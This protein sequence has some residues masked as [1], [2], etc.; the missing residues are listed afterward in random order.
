MR[1]KYLGPQHFQGEY[2]SFAYSLIDEGIY[3]KACV[4][5]AP[6]NVRGARLERLVKSPLQKYA[7]LTGKDGYLTSHI[8][9]K[10]H[11][12]SITAA[13]HFEKNIYN[14]CATQLNAKAAEERE[15]NRAAL[16]E[17]IRA[18][19]FLGRLGLPL[20]GHRDSGPLKLPDLE[21]KTITYEEGNMRALLQMMTCDGQSGLRHHLEAGAK[22]ATYI[23]PASQN[24]LITCMGY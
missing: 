4:L 22:N 15:K 18:I 2:S 23:S 9:N 13:N 8:K 3:C 20:R 16:R 17:I 12:D 14:D 5:F 7:H 1:K 24:K 19:E 10:F 6:E 11:E 21:S